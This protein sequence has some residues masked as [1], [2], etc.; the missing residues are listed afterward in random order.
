MN[1]TYMGGDHINQIGKQEEVYKKLLNG[2]AK[3]S[4]L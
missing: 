4:N 1:G 2:T 3:L